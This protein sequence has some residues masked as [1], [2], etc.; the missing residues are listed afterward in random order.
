MLAYQLKGFLQ[1][2]RMIEAFFGLDKNIVDVDFH[3]LTHQWSEY[4]GHR[5]LIGRFGI[6]QAKRHYIVVV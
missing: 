1:V 3:S 2:L 5:P 4:L 6:L